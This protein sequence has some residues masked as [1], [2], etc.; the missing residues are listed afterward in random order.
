MK[1]TEESGIILKQFARLYFYGLVRSASV[2]RK[3]S[4]AED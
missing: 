1:F 3:L 2:A 4:P